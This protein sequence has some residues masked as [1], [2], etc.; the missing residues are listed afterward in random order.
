MVVSA[1]FGRRS[2]FYLYGLIVY[3]SSALWGNATAMHEGGIS[4]AQL[5][6]R[7]ADC[8]RIRDSCSSPLRVGIGCSED[9]DSGVCRVEEVRASLMLSSNIFCW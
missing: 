3:P 2:W 1:P 7:E 8:S 5:L 9:S 6:T 4:V